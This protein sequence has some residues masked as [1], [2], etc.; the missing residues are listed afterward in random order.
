MKINYIL[1]VLILLG[2]NSC[3]EEGGNA[4]DGVGNNYVRIAGADQDLNAIGFNAVPGN[5]TLPVFTLQ[6]D[7]NS[8]SNLNT[9]V[10]VVMKLDT[11]LI[12]AYNRENHTSLI[13]LPA[14]LYELKSL[15]TTLASGEFAKK[16][17]ITVDPLKFDLSK[18]YALGITIVSA[19]NGYVVN[20]GHKSGLFSIGVKNQFD[21][22]YNVTGTMV[23]YTSAALTGFFPMKYHLVTSGANVV[24]GYEPYWE[25]RYVSILSSGARNVY[26]AFA[27]VFTIDPATNKIISVTNWW[28]QPA[29]NTRS[30]E[31]DPTGLNRFNP[32]DHSIDV[33][34]F[35]KQPSVVP[36]APNIRVA[37]DWRMTYIGPR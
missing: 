6:K 12:G 13:P 10:D 32:A 31:L 1:S 11:G 34:F 19:S 5:A 20:D 4:I 14:N 25:E 16:I 30:A 18:T 33:K 15:T 36:A 17:T 2:L 37:F 21:G 3:I 7:A 29:S 27:P 22:S 9:S 35:M 26:G 24:D 23:D 28:G 8:E